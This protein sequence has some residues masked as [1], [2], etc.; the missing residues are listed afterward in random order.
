M[1]QVQTL[2]KELQQEKENHQEKEKSLQDQIES[3]QQQQQLRN[4]VS[5]EVDLLTEM[6]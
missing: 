5:T 6:Q 2:E 3:L 1:S 4:R